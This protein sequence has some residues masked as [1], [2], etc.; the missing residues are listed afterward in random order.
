MPHT[1]RQLFT[2]IYRFARPYLFILLIITPYL[3]TRCANQGTLTG[4]A[5]DE[6][7]P[8]IISSVPPNYTTHFSSKTVELTFNEYFILKDIAKQ[9][10]VSP[11]MKEKPEFKTKGKTLEIQFKDSL[12]PDRTYAINFGDALTDL[13]EGNPIKNFQYVFS[14]G[15]TIDSL[16]A[17]GRVIDA[18]D[19]KPVESILVML[20]SNKADSSK[21]NSLI[22]DSL[23]LTSIPLYIS[24]TNKEGKFTLRNLAAGEYKIFALKDGNTNYLFD[25]AAESVGF[26]DS[27]VVP[28]IKLRPVK[29]TLAIVKDSLAE[30]KDSLGIENEREEL[31]KDSLLIAR[32][33]SSKLNRDSL[34]MVAK[35]AKYIY[36]PENLELRLFT[37]VKRNQYLAGA[38][39]LRRDQIR[40][41]LNEPT[42]SIGFEFLDMPA[43][44]V[45]ISLEWSGDADTVD[46]WILNPTMA[47][48]DSMTAILQYPALDSIERRIV[49]TDTV[50]LRYRA[51]VS[52]GKKP[53]KDF[54]VGA[55]IES[56]KTLEYGES[57]ILTTSLPYNQIDTARILL[58]TG[59]DSAAV[60]MPY[61]LTNDTLRGIVLN[62]EK[63]DQTHPRIL[64]INANWVA[65]TTYRLTLL[66][67]VFSGINGEK[68]D[69]LDMR[70]K[71]KSKDLYGSLKFNLLNLKGPAVVEV[72]DSRGKVLATRRI[73]DAGEVGF[74]R[75][76]PGKYTARLILDTN[77]NGKWDTGRYIKHIQPERVI[78]FTKEIN[79][80]ANW[81]MS[82][83]WEW[84]DI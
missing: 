76:A 68:S 1:S 10:V 12:L 83:N 74:E 8:D 44:S 18:V 62:G 25:Q 23:P 27:L 61:E 77:G 72:L 78:P 24:R 6:T 32:R 67:G 19:G 52:T 37:E 69:S 48:R 65:D 66:P 21:L 11:P 3:F 4:G 5:K 38:D 80:K 20:Y 36:F 14:T 53:K 55:S 41:K 59:K 84:E 9:L 28:S 54:T 30:T 43:D 39:R 40:V 7:P 2:P 71:M 34:A 70:F 16:E 29:D 56:T 58:V 33:D 60:A 73:T 15:S 82:E 35:R 75:L 81:E 63:I 46:F 13:N 31:G 26:Q 42:D 79:L 57:I 51:P 47:A 49:K 64:K 50:K 22:L 17:A 45:A